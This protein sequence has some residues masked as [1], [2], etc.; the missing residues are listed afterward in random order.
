MKT[1]DI[2]EFLSNIFDDKF[3][4]TLEL[5]SNNHI[6]A[7]KT[8]SKKLPIKI[9]HIENGKPSVENISYSEDGFNNIKKD[10]TKLMLFINRIKK[11]LNESNSIYIPHFS[12][13]INE[14]K[15][16]YKVYHRSKGELEDEIENYAEKRGYEV[17][18]DDMFTL[19]TT[20]L[21]NEENIRKSLELT[22][23]GK[24]QK[25]MIHVQIYRL[26]SGNYEL[27]MYIN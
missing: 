20:N 19:G 12:T 27:N 15:S 22:K 14:S 1:T 2:K 8:K 6:K 23:N 9:I 24:P 17:D 11:G 16:M 25:K 13:F 3:P 21:Y 18:L 4:T 26:S 10:S 7:I 5:D